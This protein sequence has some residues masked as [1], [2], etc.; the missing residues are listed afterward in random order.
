M[1]KL[2]ATLLLTLATLGPSA[3]IAADLEWKPETEEAALRILANARESTDG[4]FRFDVEYLSSHVDP[5]WGAEKRSRVRV[6]CEDSVGYILEYRAIDDAFMKSPRHSASGEYYKLS[7]GRI[8]TWLF[9]GK[10][11][12]VVDE[13]RRTYATDEVRP[14]DWFGPFLTVL[15]H[16]AI[17]PWLDPTIDW[18][19]LKSRFRIERAASTPTQFLVD[20]AA[21]PRLT[22]Q[23]GWLFARWEPSDGRLEGN[24][25]LVID[26][27]TLRPKKWWMKTE[28]GHEATFIYTRFDVNLPPRELKVSL[29]GYKLRAE[30]KPSQDDS[31]PLVDTASLAVAARILFWLFF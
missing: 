11:L 12:T 13:E 25:R 9:N 28:A 6:Y 21:K 29:A 27:A 4:L 14:N 19:E 15:A 1:L 24:H 17:P 23:V 8:E 7:R 10:Q 22:P 18:D 3:L 30:T 5:A 20:F 16:Q 26:R 31:K 2:C